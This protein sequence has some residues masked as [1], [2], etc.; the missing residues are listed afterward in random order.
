MLIQKQCGYSAEELKQGG[1]PWKLVEG[2]TA[3]Q[4]KY[5]DPANKKGQRVWSEGKMG[6][7]TDTDTNAVG[8]YCKIQYDDGSKNTDHRIEYLRFANAPGKNYPTIP[9]YAILEE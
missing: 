7:I 3:W 1:F 9:C 5:K 8:S 6:T 2:K 4:M